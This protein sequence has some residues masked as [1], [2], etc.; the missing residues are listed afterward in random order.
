MLDFEEEYRKVFLLDP[1]ELKF[2]MDDLRGV[3]MTLPE[4]AQTLLDGNVEPQY[5]GEKYK[6]SAGYKNLLMVIACQDNLVVDFAD[7]VKRQNQYYADFEVA[8]KAHIAQKEQP[9]TP[10]T[11]EG[12]GSSSST[13]IGSEDTITFSFPTEGGE[14]TITWSS[15]SK[16][17]TSSGPV[18][19]VAVWN[20]SNSLDREFHSPPHYWVARVAHFGWSEAAPTFL[21]AK[22]MEGIS[23][24]A[25]FVRGES[26][27]GRAGFTPKQWLQVVKVNF[28]KTQKFPEDTVNIVNSIQLGHSLDPE[29]L[30]ELGNLSLGYP[31]DKRPG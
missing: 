22:D 15:E 13:S 21:H 8:L 19:T 12:E 3:S 4:L 28:G 24:P 10:P 5:L 16:Y 6:T 17:G 30:L 20:P 2:M 23:L 11:P 31:K 27:P 7:I 14:G 18:S 25:R 26:R 29:S 9:S 1:D